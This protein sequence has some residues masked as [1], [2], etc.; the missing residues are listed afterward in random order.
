MR[1][2]V[3]LTAE[4]H[5]DCDHVLGVCVVYPGRVVVCEHGRVKAGCDTC[6]EDYLAVEARR[7]LLELVDEPPEETLEVVEG[8]LEAAGG[9][10]EGP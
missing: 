6:F 10:L 1:Y 3:S 2:A 7:A 8:Q 4:S 9:Q 5:A